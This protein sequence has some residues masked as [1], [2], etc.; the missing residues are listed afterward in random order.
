MGNNS[1]DEN[2]TLP[3]IEDQTAH[4]SDEQNYFTPDRLHH[5]LIDLRCISHGRTLYIHNLRS[6]E[7]SLNFAGNDV[8]FITEH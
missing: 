6:A 8:H 2:P 7:E 3:Q 1:G 4:D 5:R